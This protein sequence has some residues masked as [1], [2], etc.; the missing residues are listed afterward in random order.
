MNNKS[1]KNTN[2]IPLPKKIQ[3]AHPFMRQIRASWISNTSHCKKDSPCGRKSLTKHDAGMCEEWS[4]ELGFLK[5]YIWHIDNG[6]IPGRAKL[7]RKDITKGFNPENCVI[8]DKTKETKNKSPRK[9]V[10]SKGKSQEK[11]M[12]SQE[13]ISTDNIES[14]LGGFGI[15]KDG[16]SKVINIFM[17]NRNEG[18]K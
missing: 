5:Y 4:G 1:N 16:L 12:K 8:V 3:E 11:N 18:S 13:I 14:I 17:F 6:Y 2:E 10:T 7:E 15:N 9:P